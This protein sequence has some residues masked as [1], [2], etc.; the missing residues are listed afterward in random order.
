MEILCLFYFFF[1]KITI[2]KKIRNA[3]WCKTIA[4]SHSFCITLYLLYC[5]MSLKLSL[6]LFYF[7]CG[8]FILCDGYNVI[9]PLYIVIW[10]AALCK[11]LKFAFCA[12]RVWH[13]WSRLSNWIWTSYRTWVTKFLIRKLI[14][15][16]TFNVCIFRLSMSTDNTRKHF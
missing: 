11:M 1:R 9:L 13:A 15:F 7:I 2:K 4:Q 5:Y 12:K 14:I 10:P 6:T 8:N 3:R 16:F